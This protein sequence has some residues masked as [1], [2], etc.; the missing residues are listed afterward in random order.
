MKPK[1]FQFLVLNTQAD[2]E[3]GD[4]QNLAVDDEG[5]RLKSG[6]Q[7][8]AEHKLSAVEV[9]D[10]ALGDLAQVYGLDANNRRIVQFDSQQNYAESIDVFQ[11]RFVQPTH[12]AYSRPNI[13]VAD[14]FKPSEFTYQ[15]RIYAFAERLN[16][17]IRWVVTLPAGVGVVDLAADRKGTLYV[18]LNIGEQIIVKYAPSG[19]PIPTAGFARGE[20][21]AP[22]AIALAPNQDNP[23]DQDICVLDTEAVVRFKSDGNLAEL[24]PILDLGE[25]LPDSVQ[26]SGLAVDSDGN[27]YIGDRRPRS[28]GEE[29][30]RFIF[31]LDPS[32][33]TATPVVG[34]R[35]AAAKLALDRTHRL[36]I[37][38]PERR[39]INILRGEKRFL[40][41]QRQNLLVCQI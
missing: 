21:R 14:E 34:Y 33:D 27:L 35:G 18:L 22:Q 36:C 3:R 29:E 23:A 9:T 30:E 26:P 19:R 24:Q 8:V 31:C 10:L 4:L 40:R 32:A 17:Q 11:D 16:W 7:F 2:W 13:Y 15:T 12:I 1:E 39:E 28:V 41:T 6:L 5:V 38:N 25:R 37:L 20:L